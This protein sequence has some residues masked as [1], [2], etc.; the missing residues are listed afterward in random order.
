MLDLALPLAALLPDRAGPYIALVF[1]G[2]A[3]GVLGH[4]S[5]SRWLVAIGV[6][7]I[8]LGAFLFPLALDLTTDEAPPVRTTR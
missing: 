1:V 5:R 3:I 8:A 6:I 7:L 2:F 4:F